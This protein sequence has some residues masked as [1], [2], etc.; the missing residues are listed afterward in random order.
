MLGSLTTPNGLSPGSPERYWAC[1]RYFSACAASQDLR[2]RTAFTD[3]DPHQKGILSDDF[4]VAVSTEWFVRQLGGVNDIVD[5]R[6]FIINM[7]VRRPK[8]GRLPKVGPGKCPDFVIEDQ[9]GKYHVL[10][11]KGTQSGRGYLNTAMATGRVQ[12]HGVRIARA[13]RGERLVI[14]LALAGEEDD[15][16]SQLVVID[17]EEEP[18]TELR[19]SDASRASQV[20]TR[21]SL[22]R[23]LNLNG[24]N[25]TAFEIAWPE[26]MDPS[27]PEAELLSV[28]ERRG[29]S[30]KLDDRRRAWKDELAAELRSPPRRQLDDFFVQEMRFDIPAISLDS[31]AGLVTSVTVRR[32]IQSSLIKN[33]FNSGNDLRAAAIDVANTVATNQARVSF[34]E[35]KN[36][37]RLNYNNLFFSEILFE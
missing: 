28:A 13:L 9:Q 23:A 19:E 34:E 17:P 1:I 18:L 22:A 20:L 24:F 30:R 11:C 37:A 33:L 12:K 4:G 32:G 35:D 16:Q 26:K 3:L 21:L 14:G 7:G 27:S 2:I 29:F 31:G 5:G 10:E 25:Q 6:R 8:S 15:Y 36:Y